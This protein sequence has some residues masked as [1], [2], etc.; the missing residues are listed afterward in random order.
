M[1]TKYSTTQKIAADAKKSIGSEDYSEIIN[2]VSDKQAL[3]LAVVTLDKAVSHGGFSEWRLNGYGR[4]KRAMRILNNFLPKINTSEAKAVLN[5]K[6][7]YSYSISQKQNV[8]STKQYREVRKPFMKQ[9]NQY[10][11]NLA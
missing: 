3:A 7:A 10:I 9:V 1:R 4:S 8:L 11:E 5:A 2:K 6:K